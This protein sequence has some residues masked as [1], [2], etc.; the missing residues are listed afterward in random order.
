MKTLNYFSDKIRAFKE[1]KTPK[2]SRD[3]DTSTYELNPTFY[4]ENFEESSTDSRT[5][6]ILLSQLYSVENETLFI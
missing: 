4:D 5:T 6:N 1:L 2:K 3:G